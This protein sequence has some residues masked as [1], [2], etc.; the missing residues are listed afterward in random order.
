MQHH[1]AD[2]DDRPRD[3]G[4]RQ[5]RDHVDLKTLN[6]SRLRRGG[7]VLRDLLRGIFVVYPGDYLA[8]KRA[9][10]VVCIASS[11]RCLRGQPLR[12]SIQAWFRLTIAGESFEIAEERTG[13]W[14]PKHRQKDEE[15]KDRF[16]LCCK[17]KNVASMGNDGKRVQRDEDYGA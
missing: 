10:E 13:H 11:R 2:A 16:H 12:R 7:K 3:F 9:A 5:Q 8:R 15:E 14:D 6:T 4:Q 17:S 1:T